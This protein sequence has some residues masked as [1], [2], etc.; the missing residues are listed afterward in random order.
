MSESPRLWPVDTLE[1]ATNKTSHPII[2]ILNAAIKKEQAKM[3]KDLVFKSSAA[4][5]GSV[6]VVI[7]NN[8]SYIA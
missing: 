8:G 7:E 4:F 1:Q 3:F 5:L 6:E 2:N